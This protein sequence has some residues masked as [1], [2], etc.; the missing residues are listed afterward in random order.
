MS[1]QEDMQY[2]SDDE[3]SKPGHDASQ[4]IEQ[5]DEDLQRHH[6]LRELHIGAL[7][8]FFEEINEVERFRALPKSQLRVRKERMQKHF[9]DMENA[10][11]LYRQVCILASDVIY[12]DMEL[13]FMEAMSTIEERLK[14]LC[15]HEQK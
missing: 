13:R 2:G 9:N 8:R 14:E 5:R 6:I 12:E 10:H 11:V 7:N 15:S 3:I 4:R 1:D